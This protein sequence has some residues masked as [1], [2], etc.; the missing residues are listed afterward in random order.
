MVTHW[1]Q[2]IAYDSECDYNTGDAPI[3]YKPSPFDRMPVYEA[4]VPGDQPLNL[5]R[6]Y[7]Q[8]IANAWA[9]KIARPLR[10]FGE[11]LEEA[12][13]KTRTAL[14]SEMMEPVAGSDL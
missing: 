6:R 11:C 13:E 4:Y 8:I 10:P 7:A 5:D 12:Y 14:T 9:A 2:I 1:N 3:F